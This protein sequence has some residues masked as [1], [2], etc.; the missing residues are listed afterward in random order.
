[1]PKQLSKRNVIMASIVAA[2]SILS[3]ISMFADVPDKID[4]WIHT[5]EEAKEEHRVITTAAEDAQQTQA[6]FNAY[7]LKQILMQEIE[8]L[9]L[10]VDAVADPEEKE[11]LQLELDKKKAFI[12]QL[13]E[14]AR[15]QMMKGSQG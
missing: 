12:L 10:Q 11:V 7:T 2:I 3:A 8:I 5:E 1:M 9:E 14:E 13:E 15:K 4:P 6:G